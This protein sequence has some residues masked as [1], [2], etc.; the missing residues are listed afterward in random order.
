MKT[1]VSN[2]ESR[3]K[4]SSTPE[5][6]AMTLFQLGWEL[7]EESAEYS[8]DL[9][10]EASEIATGLK[11]ER[12]SALASFLESAC[13]YLIGNY[14]S[15][16]SRLLELVPHFES[17]QDNY[18]KS[19]VLNWIGNCYFR[20]GDYAFALDYFTKS[21]KLKEEQKDRLGLAYSINDIGS[22]HQ[23]LGDYHKALEFYF[24]SLKIKQE[25][26]H[27]K[28]K[29]FTLN[30]IGTA[31][32]KLGEDEKAIDYYLR[33]FEI[34]QSVNDQRGMGITLSNLGELYQ[35]GGDVEKA[36][37]CYSQSLVY[38]RLVRNRFNEAATLIRYGRLLLSKKSIDEAFSE[39]HLGMSI[40]V[41]MKAKEWIAE[42]H[43][44]L[45]QCY[46]FENNIASALMHFKQYHKVNEEIFSRESD[47]KMKTHFVQLE[48]E[49]SQKEA[50]IY[51]LKNI[52]LVQANA[53]LQ[54]TMRRLK[55]SDQQKTLLL[56]QVRE[57]SEALEKQSKE[58]SL[59]SLYNRRYL[60]KYLSIEFE[61]AKRYD[62]PLSV[63]MA[64]IDYFK[65][66]NDRFSHQV[67]DRVLR[68][69]AQIFKKNSR[70]SDVVARYGG[71]EFVLVMP[72]TI[73]ENAYIVCEKIRQSVETYDWKSIHPNLTLTISIGIAQSD[74]ID[75]YEKL[76]GKADENLYVAKD[77]GR[78][79][80]VT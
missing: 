44:A 53:M 13:Y 59:T 37:Q 60:D 28:S 61:R 50:E 75:N 19:H 56:K 78:N 1:K 57:Q 47:R 46:E 58:D 42:A 29:A 45:S 74:D 24:Q 68:E 5:E 25:L 43:L 80:V 4:D 30:L 21:I 8:L 16:L 20:L 52:E 11:D 55:D 48:T 26:G 12:L 65:K 63:A 70:I 34:L 22:V 35:I 33:S 79:L 23:A 40:A 17:L 10:K 27:E 6:R 36:E 32:Q 14:N 76:I 71:E 73:K 41:E 72:E 7:K 15:A 67:G 31:Y 3:L 54:E 64:D 2:L 51:R 62:R 9:A 77:K 18:Y 38:A 66:V 69:V 49:R 39:I